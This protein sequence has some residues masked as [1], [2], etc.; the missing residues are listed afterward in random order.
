MSRKSIEI[1]QKHLAKL[2]EMVIEFI[3]FKLLRS[4]DCD[5]L[6]ELVSDKTN[7]N[8][9]GITF[10]RLYGF[11]KYPF[12]P[13]IQT[14]DILS[15]FIGYKN[16]YEFEFSIN[17]YQ[18]ISN[19]ELGILLSFYDFDLINN[20]EFHDG[21]IQSMSRKILLRFREDVLTFKR[22]IPKLAKMKY[23]R[24]FFIEHFP[25]YD[26]LC[27]YYYLLYEEYLANSKG[28]K[29]KLFGRTML[30]LKGFW[31]MD[32]ADC[33]KYIV[34]INKVHLE[35]DFHPYLIGRY[36]ACNMLYECYYG[37]KESI[38]RLY[39]E[40]LQIRTSIPKTGN[41]FKDFPASEYIIA[42]TLIHVHAYTQ[43]IELIEMAFE[44]F[45]FKMEFV[46]KGYYRQMQLVWLIAKKK[47]DSNFEIKMN[48]EKIKTADFYFISQK[49]FTVI[50]QYVTYLKTGNEDNLIDAKALSEEM[51]NK[52]LSEVF[53]V[54]K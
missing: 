33:Q 2:K 20:I 44:D 13:S 24:L 21:G 30:F 25:D 45:S 4:V 35:N 47:I 14:L 11:T 41:H 27:N 19:S 23:A 37:D 10:K 39:D 9:N 12:N 7:T 38:Y 5:K 31:S 36:F 17:D 15:Q 54:D 48:L 6:A 42:E 22:A 32:Q 28:D 16:W 50:Y 1:N 29:A 52:Y 53:L 3:D 18:P 49:Y 43:C 26:N 40:Y 51:G 46:R 34:E 8:V